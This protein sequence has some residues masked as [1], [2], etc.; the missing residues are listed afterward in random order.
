MREKCTH[1]LET[2]LE[3]TLTEASTA[4]VESVFAD[5]GVLAAADTA[6]GS[7]KID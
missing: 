3:G 7:E 4:D 1:L 5:E 2:K 6:G